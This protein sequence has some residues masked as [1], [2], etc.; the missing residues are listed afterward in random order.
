MYKDV[1]KKFGAK[2]FIVLCS[3][4]LVG[5]VAI[6][7][8]RL[9]AADRGVSLENV[10]FVEAGGNEPSITSGAAIITLN[11]ADQ[12]YSLDENGGV[13]AAIPSS[14]TL[15][16]LNDNGKETTETIYEGNDYIFA[17]NTEEDQAKKIAPDGVDIKIK[18]ARGSNY[19][20]DDA[21]T[22]TITYNIK[23]SS[24]KKI[25][26][27]AIQTNN[28]GYQNITRTVLVSNG[29][30]AITP[31]NI[32]INVTYG[33]KTFFLPES[34]YDIYEAQGSSGS[35]T[36]TN[37]LNP[38]PNKLGRYAVYI[39]YKNFYLG[40]NENVVS[41]SFEF[42]IK[43]DASNFTIQAWA[44]DKGTQE[45]IPTNV[46]V[47]PMKV[48]V[49]DGTTDVSAFFDFSYPY[50]TKGDGTT[51]KQVVAKPKETSN[52][53]GD[54]IK[55]WT[56]SEKPLDVK[57]RNGRPDGTLD[58]MDYDNAVDG[59]KGVQTYE[60]Q[61]QPLTV[62]VGGTDYALDINRYEIIGYTVVKSERD[63]TPI[64]GG[65]AGII[66]MEIQTDSTYNP[67]PNTTGYLYY[68]IR[69]NIANARFKDNEGDE[70]ANQIKYNGNTHYRTP[71]IYFNDAPD[72]VE[73]KLV[74]DTDYTLTYS[75]KKRGDGSVVT[76]SG[77]DVVTD[78]GTVSMTVTGKAGTG[79]PG[80]RTDL[81][82]YYG[83]LTGESYPDALTYTI[84]AK[85]ISEYDMSYND[86]TYQL[87]DTP[88]NVATAETNVYFKPKDENLR[89]IYLAHMT[90]IKDY[91]ID[92]YFK[93]ACAES[94]YIENWQQSVEDGDIEAGGTYYAK[95]T[96]T[97]N[98]KDFVVIPLKMVA[99][100]LTNVKIDV[101]DWCNQEGETDGKHIYNGK[102]HS[103]N[104]VVTVKDDPSRPP[105]VQ[106]DR[107]GRGDYWLEYDAASDRVNVSGQDQNV[108]VTI[109]FKSGAETT[110][111]FKIHPRQV[112][113]GKVK[114][115]A[116]G[117]QNTSS[118]TTHL[119]N[120][121]GDDKVPA[122]DKLEL[123]YQKA[124]GSTETLTMYEKAGVQIED[125]TLSNDDYDV[126]PGLYDANGNKVNLNSIS[127]DASYY[128]AIEP[129]GNF[130]GKFI[131]GD[132]K[133]VLAG[134]FKFI[135]KDL[136]AKEIT[137]RD[138]STKGDLVMTRW[139]FDTEA[140]YRQ[141]VEEWLNSH[142]EVW[143]E[144]LK[145]AVDPGNYTIDL[146]NS[147]KIDE[148]GTIVFRIVATPNG[149]YENE[150]EKLIIY[151]GEDIAK[152][153]VR[154]KGTTV[155]HS[156]VNRE[157]TLDNPYSKVSSTGDLYGLN[158]GDA[159]DGSYTCV[160]SGG[161]N[162]TDIIGVN[163]KYTVGTFI[164]PV[165]DSSNP[166]KQQMASVTL[167][168]K[169]GFHGT[170]TIYIKVE[171][172]HFD[173]THYEI[174]IPDQIYNGKEQTPA[175]T[176]WYSA[177]GKSDA[178][179]NPTDW[180]RL[181]DD[182]YDPNTVEW[183]RNKNANEIYGTNGK[184]D[185]N[186]LSQVTIHGQFGYDGP[187]K[188]WFVIKPFD[189]T[190]GTDGVDNMNINGIRFNDGY[191][192]LSGIM[193]VPYTY[194]DS[195]SAAEG[196]TDTGN[197]T[198][199]GAWQTFKLN[200]Y[201]DGLSGAPIEL[202][203][204]DYS[205]YCT[206]AA[207]ANQY[208]KNT[209]PKKVGDCY[210]VIEG[211][212]NFTGIIH[213]KYR[214]NQVN[215]SESCFVRFVNN[216]KWNQ[217]TGEEIL[218]KI[219]VIQK[220]ENGK[221]Y[222]L[223]E[224]EDYTLTYSDNKRFITND[225]NNPTTCTTWIQIDEA[226]NGNYIE[227]FTEP[228][229][230][231]ADLDPGNGLTT[232]SKNLRLYWGTDPKLKISYQNVISKSF[233]GLNL[234]VQQWKEGG[235][236]GSG[237]LDVDYTTYPMKIGTPPTSADVADY[238]VEFPVETIGGSDDNPRTMIVRGLSD[239]VSKGVI[240]TSGPNGVTVPA[241]IF[242]SLQNVDE[243]RLWENNGGS[244]NISMSIT[245]GSAISHEDL[246]K[247]LTVYCG[248]RPLVW[249][250]D[251]I[252]EGQMN[253]TIGQGSILIKPTPEALAAGYLTDDTKRIDYNLVSAI[254]GMV[255]NI[256]D[257]YIYK[258]QKFFN[259]ATTDFGLSLNGKNLINGIDYTVTV[260]DENDTEVTEPE[261]C[262][263]YNYLIVGIGSYGDRIT[264]SFRIR[265]YDLGADY[266]QGKVTIE[267]KNQGRVT[268]TGS[269][270][271]PEVVSVTVKHGDYDTPY[272]LVQI[273]DS[274]AGDYGVRTAKDRDDPVHVNWT[275]SDGEIPK[276]AV[277]GMNNYTG[278]VTANYLIEKKS[279]EDSDIFIDDILGLKYQNGIEIKPVPTIT[280]RETPDKDA[281]ILL[282]LSGEEYSSD[283]DSEYGSQYRI[284]FT[285]RYL[286]NVKNAGTKH[287]EIVGVGNFT[288]KRSITYT[289]DP[290]PLSDTKLTFLSEEAPVYDSLPQTPAF[291]LSYGNI[292]NILTV[293]NGKPVT[294]EFLKASDVEVKFYDNT[295]ASTEEKKASVTVKIIAGSN[296]EGEITKEFTV[297]PAPLEEHVRFMYRPKGASADVDLKSYKLTFPFI[298]VGSPVYPKYA[299]ADAELAEEEIGM[300]YNYPSKANHGKFL[301]P[302]ADYGSQEDPD[303]I[304]I[305][306]KYVEPDTDDTDIRE[307][308]QRPTPDYAGK[309]RVTIT[310]KRNY[311]GKASFWYFIGD[312]IS[313]DA[314]ISISPTTAVFNSQNQYPTVTIS[315][316]DKNKCT[317][318]NYRG[319]V[320]VENLITD[321]DFIDAGTY[322]IRVEGDPSKGTYATKPETL[323]FTITPR[324]FSNSLVIDGFK[325]EYAYTGYEIRP[326]G[327]SV[328]DYI[329]NIKYRLTEEEDY[330]LTYSNNL[331]AGIAYINVKGQGNFSGSASTNFLITSS[332]IS[333][334]GWN[335][336]NSFLDEGSGEISGA[337][338]VA[339]NNVKLTM[340]TSDAMYYTGKAVYPK[341]S[342]SGMTENVDYTVTFSNNVE[343]GMGV[344][345]INGIGN[346]NGVI[347]KNFR[348]IAPLSKCT[349][350]PIPAQQYTGSAV[351]PSLTVRC[352]NTVL[353]EGTDYTVTY[354]NNIN[355]GTA[356]ATIR[357]LN[358]A[359]FTGS[360][361]VKFSIGND[362]GGFIISGFAPSYAYTGNAITPGVVVETGSS[363]LTL[364]TDYTVS[365]SNN[366]N[367]GT[368]TITVT[369][370]GKYSG[371][372]TANFIIE[373]KSIQSCDT[374]EVTDRTYTGDAYT[375]DIT[376]SDG[377][378]VLTKGVD[379]TVT[380]TNNTNP[381]TASILI[382]GMSNNYTG[383]KVISFKI[384][385]VAVKG[386]KSSSVKYNSLKLTWTKQGYA[387]GYQ[388]CN[389]SSKVVK[390]VKKNSASITG[391]SAG[392]TY[393]YKVR[394]YVRNADGTKS[395]GAFSSVLSVT[396][397]LRTPTVKVVSNAKGQARISWS[398][399][400][401]A[402]GYEIYYKKS[403]KAK[404]KKLKT[405]NNP[406]VRVC[407]VRGMKSGDRAYFRIR[408]FR[409][410][411]SKKVYSALNPLK[412]IT[413]K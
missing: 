306:Y 235:S 295:D 201:P 301:V 413:V 77:K 206:A 13:I 304:N 217:F 351:T 256:K 183:L 70:D 310:G 381:G 126:L 368:A 211:K 35:Y 93:Q 26:T 25:A 68:G 45:Y 243:D 156:F 4:L 136:G 198:V 56:V 212:N 384:S 142:L 44:D 108:L 316:V 278:Q 311:T 394:S 46:S 223:T 358:N 334:G 326:V 194:L 189:I 207:A 342:I 61:K 260:T 283:K 349:I 345:T 315:G 6:A 23:K 172:H 170:V 318:G 105:L 232:A 393:K 16:Y 406:N 102:Q 363:T 405:V 274:N 216:K 361:S 111:K 241:V 269:S 38:V 205:Y 187:L 158:F 369:G 193:Y 145:Q 65:T 288:G 374:T 249:G 327:I 242:D 350:S 36:E 387:D 262:G 343:V 228:Y 339:P 373:A 51:V 268:F 234:S 230:I 32:K 344:A 76:G 362:V 366:V 85:S 196:I 248:G 154:E 18:A 80:S 73:Y 157:T 209:K 279:I 121:I 291:K 404:Y 309:V 402:S 200:F 15:K 49:F 188:G 389:S 224:G 163:Q 125:G 66:M 238:T 251:Y 160:Y 103:L 177:T 54:V 31:K 323:T 72:N 71:Y 167:T 42:D 60:I 168:G 48:Q 292:D 370:T 379:Y 408:A 215:M 195:N 55:S 82:G 270:V 377:G 118:G 109:K 147:N 27:D 346:N 341:V 255:P 11:Q 281:K 299:P 399:V 90:P 162:F 365:Y 106:G 58:V 364:G 143:D 378:K 135:K 96:F 141:K 181:P 175:F 261:N 22:C 411:G 214:V 191:N 5:G 328:T 244:S 388:I 8:P 24:L 286:D 239:G 398:K 152:T 199:E 372:Q 144:D 130:E 321:K 100:E 107:P 155:Y 12:F 178:N 336:S 171:N 225:W 276:A 282:T 87:E 340:D 10:I 50:E 139:K 313:S 226:S 258:H 128:Y 180:E 113:T 324:A 307:E 20:V 161:R 146:D 99:Y 81:P 132:K 314:K 98:Q 63:N 250:K 210:A 267:L 120:G 329:D 92:Y 213:A 30:E 89:T 29:N 40:N 302:S 220:A 382:Q 354:S 229:V 403:S 273:D 287:M 221:T 67:A 122:L 222:K 129:K 153:E 264:G 185:T 353:M 331:N 119:F 74:K 359:N 252:F 133:Y 333:S 246:S 371:T 112:E 173:Q 320:L 131:S 166:Q 383:T 62:R 401:G 380:Y 84:Q 34:E 137:Y 253:T 1:W 184:Y 355:I 64:P 407:T 123:S 332:T 227:G 21:K 14:L 83:T 347:T 322:F 101:K 265:P 17:D 138:K 305:E 297:L 337:V 237:K 151:T 245:T 392:K 117:F 202:T 330:V 290:L 231:Y 303:G 308:Y 116:T 104:V 400:S 37:N 19:L 86:V 284:H 397:K 247:I 254:T 319:E 174:R 186:E 88:P 203:K 134:P 78:A 140:E 338:P 280:Y 236:Y 53:I 348:I 298:G 263:T 233:E 360:A 296:Y 169:S 75:L 285:Y 91:S 165:K 367:A 325:K 312:D 275:D 115:T 293:R 57:F 385:A 390:T 94:D 240:R 375:P 79:E 150:K 110:R 28:P 95:I 257:E 259:T 317:I 197:I 289:V 114:I 277:Y 179:P 396:T 41:E 409:K 9:L 97:G 204:D 47:N 159:D 3:I 271:L 148:N 391:L 39:K 412:V 149:C 2:V 52:Y 266:A 192:T 127:M 386:L 376:V 300:Y 43:K 164:E 352:G 218:P 208:D 190:N 182:C 357:A 410:N 59:Y 69:R 395:Y 33:S 219:E 294:T 356:T 124:G 272:D 335:G 176:V 7:A